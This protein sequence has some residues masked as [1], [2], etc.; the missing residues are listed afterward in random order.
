[1]IEVAYEDFV[2]FLDQYF[3]E[4]LNGK[5]FLTVIK[6]GRKIVLMD[7]VNFRILNSAFEIA[8]SILDR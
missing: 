7:N 8:Q 4:L 3:K 1:M 6:D 2:K 5:E